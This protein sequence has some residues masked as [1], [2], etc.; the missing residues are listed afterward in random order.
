M[1]E[2]LLQFFFNKVSLE[3]IVLFKAKAARI[4]FTYDLGTSC[5]GAAYGLRSEKINGRD[6]RFCYIAGF[7]SLW[8]P[9][10]SEQNGHNKKK[11]ASQES[12][13]TGPAWEELVSL[14][15]V[16]PQE[17]DYMTRPERY[18]YVR[19]LVKPQGCVFCSSVKAGVGFESLVLYQSRLAMIVLN[20]YPYNNGHLLILPT[21][22]CGDLLE[23]S[24]DEFL[25]V[26]ACM[27]MAVQVL[28][29]TYGSGGFNI[30]LNHGAV[31]GAGIP[32]HLHWHVVPR[33]H[34]DT[35]FF[36]VIAETKV[37]AETLEQTYEHLL[38]YFEGK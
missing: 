20:K 21:R 7:E 17:R 35:N 18:K 12:S 31:A 37:I 34:G 32:E 25:E 36:P 8:G 5:R 9:S 27:R 14:E 3:K 13:K 6:F 38:P 10:M 24:E 30:G 26:N 28:K 33:W 11:G 16:W 2:C 1:S 22:H 29:N 19:K 15:E 4:F 23:L